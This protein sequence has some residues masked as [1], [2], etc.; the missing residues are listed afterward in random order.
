MRNQVDERIAERAHEQLGLFTEDDLRAAGGCWRLKQRRIASGVWEQRSPRVLAMTAHPRSWLQHVMQGVLDAG[1]R[2]LAS[3]ITGAAVLEVPT[4]GRHAGRP[5]VLIKRGGNHRP[6]LATLHE[7]FWLPDSHRRVHRQIP[8][9]SWDRLPFE[10]AIA[11][12]PRQRVE[13]VVDH[14]LNERGLR[15]EDLALSGSVLCRRGRPATPM[16]RSII[17]ERAPGYVPPASVLEAAF[18][19]LC[20]EFGL[21]KGAR[22]KNAGGDAWIGRVDVAY[23][24]AKLLVELDSRRWHGARTAFESDRERTNELVKAGWRVIRIT[25]RMIHDEPEKVAALVRALL[26]TAA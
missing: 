16:I 10:L 1:P 4:F 5:Q 11:R 20:A 6:G 17:E 8:V 21:P 9:V 14:A 13:W 25:W 15:H 22:Q 26:A 7:T 18:A 3:G 2:A 19:T 23:A 24:R 12:L